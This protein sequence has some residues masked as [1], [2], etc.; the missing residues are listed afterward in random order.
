MTMQCAG[1]HAEVS[2][3]HRFCPSCGAPAA[4]NSG[5]STATAPEGAFVAGIQTP[6]ASRIAH[7]S[8]AASFTP[9][10]VLAGR[11][12]VVG[13]LGRGGMGEVYRADDLKLGQ[14]VALKFLPQ[15]F[16]AAADRHERLIGEVRTA[17]QVTHPNVCRVYDIGELDGRQFLSMEYVDGE[18]L[19]SL[20]DRIGRLPPD[21]ALDAARQ[22]CAG[23]AAAHERGVLHRD[24]K[25]ANVMLDGRGR[26]RIMDFGL[27]VAA[28]DARVDEAGTP[29]YMAPEQLAGKGAS[30]RSDIYALGLVLY[31]LYT[32]KRAFDGPS[33]AAI[34]AAKERGE[35]RRPT[36]LIAEMDPAVERV[37]L[38]AFARDPAQRPASVA[39]LAAA[40]PGGSPLQAALRA[41]ETPSPDM[42]AASGSRGGIAPRVAW[43]LL[44]LTVALAAGAVALAS[45]VHPWR[46]AAFE[47]PPAALA[48]KARDI[49]ARLGYTT[50]APYRASG[51]EADI[52]HLRYLQQHDRSRTRW[53]RT[54][55]SFF[56]FWYR[57]SAQPL[58]SWR[59]AF[60][61][62]NYSRVDP[63]D[64]PL[65]VAGMTL[66]RLDPGGRLVQF[67]GVP[68]A[69]LQ[70]G[71]PTTINWSGLLA[72]AGFDPAAWTAVPS[73]TVPPVYADARTAWEGSWPNRPDL[74]VRLEAASLGGTPVYF[75]AIFP[76]TRPIGSPA[77]L[78]TPGERAALV[79]LFL[80]TAALIAWAA[81]F[82]MRNLRGGR[83][84]RR[85]AFRVAAFVFVTMAVAWVFGESHVPSL[86]EAR[87]AIMGVAWALLVSAICWLGYLAAEP[88][89]RRRW[90]QLLVS[91]TRVLAGDLRDPL[92]ARDLLVGCAAGAFLGAMSFVATLV[93]SWF[94][95]PANLYP[96][97]VL[98]FAYDLP[99]VVP[100]L[101]WR[102]PQSVIGGLA[103]LV[104]IL[105]LRL[106][107]RSQPR[108][109]AAYVLLHSLI[110]SL[111]FE[112]YWIAFAMSVLFHGVLVL[113]LRVGL[114]ATV[115]ATYTSGLFVLFPVTTDVQAWYAGAGLSALVV[116]FAMAGFGFVNAPGGRPLL[117]RLAMDD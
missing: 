90:P 22:I 109:M 77:D 58:E 69:A 112:Q 14:P 70:S 44:L 100:L 41:G 61:Y 88:Y 89:V 50:G 33:L 16:A 27:A 10:M 92:V 108:A 5:L 20:L 107:L 17:R 60:R 86:G 4:S 28:G 96:A 24:L 55:P 49:Q 114:L 23:L 95:V 8:V 32:G 26:V 7:D 101:V 51:Y 85:G 104:A 53:S 111:P 64:P 63:I 40:L 103:I 87:L 71:G 93:P 11:Y 59:F 38:R 83:G 78:L 30:V 1:C 99:K 105:L 48:E 21:K 6:V 34:L 72:A 52:D 2:S 98:G 39:E 9:G 116:F 84:D 113:L 68:G 115:V 37:I 102:W 110:A 18:D 97:D 75:E 3:G 106:V 35:P 74:P 80:A 19:R 54:E 82:A 47:R 56:R 43:L 65:D 25:P 42:V 62:G 15:G 13:L 73:Q 81:L 45:S 12:R 36:E 76:W 117:G 91:W 46:R 66:V 57:E 94:G 67:V 79:P 31:E 29:A